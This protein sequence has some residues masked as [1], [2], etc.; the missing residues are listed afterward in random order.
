MTLNVGQVVVELAQVVVPLVVHHWE[1]GAAGQLWQ[2][3]QG[4]KKNV[5]IIIKNTK[6]LGENVTVNHIPQ[7]IFMSVDKMC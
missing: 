7:M 6:M 3:L 4:G 1:N 2:I 5:I